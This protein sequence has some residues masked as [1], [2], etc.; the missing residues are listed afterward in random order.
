[1]AGEILDGNRVA[2]ALRERLKA[3]VATLPRPPGLAVVI[4]GEDPASQIYVRHKRRDCQEVGFHSQAFA[5]PASTRQDEL[6]ELVERLNADPQIDGFL[7]QSP[8]PAH[9]D[10]TDLLE[11]I[12]PRKDIDGFHPYNIGRLASRKPALQPCT[13][14]G[15]MRLLDTT[16]VKYHGLEALVVGA[17]NHVGRPMALEL[18]LAGCTVTVT[19]KFTRELEPHVRRAEL[20]VAAA[21]V[22]HLVKGDWIRDGAVV[23]DVGITRMDDGRLRGD[24][25]FDLARQRASWITPVP[26]GV[27]PMTR[28]ALLEN[29]FSAA[30]SQL[31]VEPERATA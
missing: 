31:G 29:T 8:L 11:R 17:S 30:C 19:H 24:V 18:L 21:G 1:M 22:P 23:V 25:E 12:D 13:P 20:V 10:E 14:M 7:I 16:G 28:A 26:G 15:I 27:G 2:K 5:L 4:V 9:L 3:A 6:V